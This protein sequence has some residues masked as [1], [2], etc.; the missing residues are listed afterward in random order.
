VRVCDS[1]HSRAFW[2]F[3]QHQSKIR[4][5]YIIY[6]NV[7]SAVLVLLSHTRT[8]VRECFKGDEAS[9]WKRPKIDPSSHQNPLTDLHKNW[10]AWLLGKQNTWFCR[11]FGVTSM[12]VFGF[13]NKATAYIP[14]RIFTKNTSF[15][16]RKCLL[17]VPMTIFYIWTLK[18]PKNRHFGAFWGSRW[19]YFIFGP[20]NFRKTAISGTDFD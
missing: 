2:A 9:Q 3:F 19:L 10:Q 4:I 15:R 17:G 8:V 20:L 16:V 12:F 5:A 6:E 11:D 13:F 7:Y 1:L 18:F 14:G